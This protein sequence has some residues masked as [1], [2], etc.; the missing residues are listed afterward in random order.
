M[1][2]F[3]AAV[4]LLALS[5]SLG[6]GAALAAPAVDQLQVVKVNGD[7][8]RLDAKGNSSTLKK[9]QIVRAPDTLRTAADASVE[10]LT[11]NGSVIKVGERSQ[12]QVTQL[13]GNETGGWTINLKIVFGKLRAIVNKIVAGKDR[14]TVEA[15]TSIAGIQGTD[16]I[17][18]VQ[19]TGPKR[20]TLF[21][22]KGQIEL[23][24]I[25]KNKIVVKENQTVSGCTTG[26][27][28]VSNL[29]PFVLNTVAS[30]LP[31]DTPIAESK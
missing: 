18:T 5:L 21:V 1:K 3:H 25:K 22:L 17:W 2:W 4:V 28:E 27:L 15:P 20:S 6:V 29:S 9:D 31:I 11:H 7:A 23:E 26:L 19:E 14:F 24:D 12:V 10:L 30:M 16:V 8:T 13:A